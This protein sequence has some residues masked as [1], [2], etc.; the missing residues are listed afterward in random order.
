MSSAQAFLNPLWLPPSG[1]RRTLTPP[2][3]DQ[4]GNESRPPRLVIGAQAGTVVAVEVL[5]EQQA[6]A[7]QRIVLELRGAAVNRPPAIG[8]A[9]EE[10][11]HPI[12]DL[13]RHPAWTDWRAVA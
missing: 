1:G 4:I 8:A 3:V 7:P 13:A 11:N 10:A 12:G 6:I 2:F 5:V 9:S